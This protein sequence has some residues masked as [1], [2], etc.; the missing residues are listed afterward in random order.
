M[1][2]ILQQEWIRLRFH[3]LIEIPFTSKCDSKRNNIE[4]NIKI[5]EQNNFRNGFLTSYE[6]V[7]ESNRNCISMGFGILEN[8]IL[9][10]K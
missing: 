2:N 8:I 4:T 7:I 1:V 5:R 3:N 10:S 6:N 9:L